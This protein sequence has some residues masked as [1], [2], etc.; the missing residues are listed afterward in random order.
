MA[1][2]VLEKK[3]TNLNKEDAKKH[4]TPI[5]WASCKG[6][7]RHCKDSYIKRSM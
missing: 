6:S 7:L 4:W 5:V 3:G 1:K 2:K